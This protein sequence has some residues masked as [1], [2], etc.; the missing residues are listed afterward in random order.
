MT[1]APREILCSQT[2]LENITENNSSI[3]NYYIDYK[4][5]I[6]LIEIKENATELKSK[7]KTNTLYN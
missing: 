4:S 3:K 7:F 5:L 1:F 2:L 6:I